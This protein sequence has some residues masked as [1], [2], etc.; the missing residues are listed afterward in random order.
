VSDS[1]ELLVERTI[2][3]EAPPERVMNAFLNPADL[4][5]WWQVVRCVTV[6]RPLGNYAV[7]WEATEYRDEILGKLG[8]T[9]H[10]TIMEYRKGIELFVADA[11]WQPPE[12]DP[13]GPMALE[14]RCRI[15][16]AAH[17]TQLSVR[18]SGIDDGPRWQ[19]YFEVVAAGWQRALSELKNYLDAEALKKQR[20]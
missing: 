9:F 2:M 7:E 10:G 8:G 1:S 11:Y 5:V 6:P 15:L 13:L 3:I 16:G 20:A 17:M 4:A 12:G 14:I 19:R 18:Q